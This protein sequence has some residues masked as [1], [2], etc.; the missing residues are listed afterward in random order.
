MTLPVVVGYDADGHCGHCQS[1]TKAHV[2]DSDGAF[3]VAC[4]HRLTYSGPVVYD[5][6]RA[7]TAFNGPRSV[8]SVR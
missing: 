1:N 7:A 4:F 3:C 8:T 5:P 2:Q 6:E